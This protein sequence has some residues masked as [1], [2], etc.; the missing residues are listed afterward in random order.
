VKRSVVAP[1]E[2]SRAKE[3]VE[4]E[5]KRELTAEERLESLRELLA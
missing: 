1:T 3:S 2:E 5:R 4:R